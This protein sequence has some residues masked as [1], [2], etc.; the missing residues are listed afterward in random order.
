M[1]VTSGLWLEA[2]RQLSDL[3]IKPPSLAPISSSVAV[4]KY[5]F[6]QRHRRCSESAGVCMYGHETRRLGAGEDFN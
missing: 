3:C 5:D 2:G 1:L 6:K 4:N